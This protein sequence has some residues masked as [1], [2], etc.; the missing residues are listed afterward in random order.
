MLQFNVSHV[1][2]WIGRGYFDCSAELSIDRLNQIDYLL[3]RSKTDCEMDYR[4]SNLASSGILRIIDFHVETASLI[5]CVALC[6]SN[7][8]VCP[9]A[10][11]FVVENV[12]S[13]A[14]HEH[15]VV[16]RL[17]R[18]SAESDLRRKIKFV[19]PLAVRTAAES[20]WNAILCTANPAVHS[21]C[22]QSGMTNGW[23]IAMWSL[24]QPASP[25]KLISSEML[26]KTFRIDW[27]LKGKL[28][29]NFG[30]SFS[31]LNAIYFASENH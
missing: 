18:N 30:I 29:C 21:H 3:L 22:P 19:L 27:I 10:I 8:R 1:I 17:S 31:S 6:Q 7:E 2:G 28:A 11:N 12:I 25:C 13:L 16:L 15:A 14:F 24:S 4:R 9:I 5:T 26:P 23:R 20:S